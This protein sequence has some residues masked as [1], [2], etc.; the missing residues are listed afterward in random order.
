MGNGT[1]NA[2]STARVQFADGTARLNAEQIFS[3]LKAASDHPG[4][5]D[6]FE[7]GMFR[8]ISEYPPGRLLSKKQ[9][10]RIRIIAADKLNFI[11]AFE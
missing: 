9:D 1:L 4:L 5:L 2:P 7:D 6:K 8:T 10:A 3:I 11:N